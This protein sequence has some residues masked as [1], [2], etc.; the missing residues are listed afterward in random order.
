M[1]SIE[2]GYPSL[3]D[4]IGA[5]VQRAARR[6]K[7]RAATSESPEDARTRRAFVQEMLSRNPEAFSSDLDVQSMMQHYPGRF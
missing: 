7:G 5:L 3:T 4:R 6:L 1:T 2:L